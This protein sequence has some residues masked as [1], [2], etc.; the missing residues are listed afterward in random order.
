MI[1][2]KDCKKCV[3]VKSKANPNYFGGCEFCFRR[4]DLGDFYFEDL[5]S[6]EVK[7]VIEECGFEVIEVKEFENERIF[8]LRFER[9]YLG[10]YKVRV[11]ERVSN[12]SYVCF[13][14][15]GIVGNKKVGYRSVEKGEALFV[16]TRCCWNHR[17]VELS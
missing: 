3:H 4:N 6:E 16:Y 7:A 2:I 14:E 1:E 10:K 11:L 9:F 8:Y 17:R 5:T 13:L 12:K 15:K